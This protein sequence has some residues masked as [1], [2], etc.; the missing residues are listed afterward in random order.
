MTVLIVLQ[1]RQGTVRRP[2]VDHD[3][4]HA[5]WR[6]LRENAV[7][8]LRQIRL[9]VIRGEDQAEKGIFLIHIYSVRAHLSVRANL[10]LSIFSY[11]S[12]LPPHASI[13]RMETA[14]PAIDFPKICAIIRRS[15]SSV[16]YRKS[17][18]SRKFTICFQFYHKLA[19]FT[20]HLEEKQP[21][22]RRFAGAAKK[23]AGTRRRGGSPAGHK[24]KIFR[25]EYKH[26]F[27][28]RTDEIKHCRARIQR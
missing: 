17:E 26:V 24:K 20:R 2:V 15:F 28:R 9:R 1:E 12:M 4:F 6:L 8:C 13:L 18:T 7:Q 10:F 5:K 14:F 25:K 19:M 27:P 11:C 23:F 3:H 22:R 21:V 16:L